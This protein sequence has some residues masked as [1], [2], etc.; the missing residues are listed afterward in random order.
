MLEILSRLLLPNNDVPT[1]LLSRRT[2]W[3]TVRRAASRHRRRQSVGTFDSRT[4]CYKA[5]LGTNRRLLRIVILSACP[6]FNFCNRIIQSCLLALYRGG[7][8][9]SWAANAR[10]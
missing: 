7:E 1:D 6:R 5:A 4:A 2:K 10:C 9:N 3:R 8:V